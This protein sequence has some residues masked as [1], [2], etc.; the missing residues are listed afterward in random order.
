MNNFVVAFLPCAKKI[1]T[2]LHSW[3][4]LASM[5]A[6]HDGVENR[7]KKTLLIYTSADTENVDDITQVCRQYGY[8]KVVVYADIA[9][10]EVKE[11]EYIKLIEDTYLSEIMSSKPDNVIIDKIF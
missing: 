11:K 5:R 8:Q 7:H 10:L 4:L 9:K 1:G 6:L 3:N 2:T